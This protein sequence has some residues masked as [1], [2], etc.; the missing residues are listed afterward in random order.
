MKPY[1]KT[2]ICSLFKPVQAD[3][4]VVLFI[5]LNG[6]KYT[7]KT[8]FYKGFLCYTLVGMSCKEFQMPFQTTLQER[9]CLSSHFEGGKNTLFVLIAEVF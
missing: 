3:I 1:A 8:H 5:G 6:Q 2:T 7:Y 4:F 9:V